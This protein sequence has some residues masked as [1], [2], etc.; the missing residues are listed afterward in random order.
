MFI[1]QIED[2]EDIELLRVNIEL[3]RNTL[4]IESMMKEDNKPVLQPI[5][6]YLKVTNGNNLLNNC[7]C[8]DIKDFID[9]IMAK[10][11]EFLKDEEGTITVAYG[12]KKF[13]AVDGNL[14]VFKRDNLS[15][16]AKKYEDNIVKGSEKPNSIQITESSVLFNGREL[17]CEI[18]TGVRKL[19][20]ELTDKK[21]IKTIYYTTIIEKEETIEKLTIDLANSEIL[22]K[23]I[24]NK[25]GMR[26]KEWVLGGYI[27]TAIKVINCET[28]ITEET[29]VPELNPDN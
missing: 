4:T 3:I 24:C 17:G 28:S 8:T 11:V 19:N 18:T 26:E 6:K 25:E 21:D 22:T 16:K 29:D 9:I 10:E 14:V 15:M 20:E 2:I 7:T 12:D 13:F 5:L 1:E 23:D 27:D